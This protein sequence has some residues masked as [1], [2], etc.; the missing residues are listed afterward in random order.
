MR[1]NELTFKVRGAIFEVYKILGPGL[2]ES[3]YEA[4]LGY[5]F[6]TLGLEYKTQ[7]PIN[8]LYKGKD[9][10]LGYRM[11]MLIEDMLVLELKSVEILTDAH[12]KQLNTYLKLAN[13]PLGLLINFNTINLN[14][15]IIRI[16]NGNISSL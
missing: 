15:N 14:D 10:G 3:T 2:L 6:D 1:L 12:K 4:A 5:E 9:L 7:V 16:V 11:D 13:K 8:V